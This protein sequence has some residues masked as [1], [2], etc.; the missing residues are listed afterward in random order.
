[1]RTRNSRTAG[2]QRIIEGMFPRGVP[3]PGTT[4]PV[5]PGLGRPKEH[6]LDGIAFWIH[7]KF[8]WFLSVGLPFPQEDRKEG[9]LR[10][11]NGRGLTNELGLLSGPS[12]L[13][14]QPRAFVCCVFAATTISTAFA[15]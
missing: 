15:H 8:H 10:S 13:E 5:Q 6:S 3:D 9:S 1:M 14:R 2:G 7:A 12:T 11:I 4:R